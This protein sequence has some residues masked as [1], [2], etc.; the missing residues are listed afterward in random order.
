MALEADLTAEGKCELL[1]IARESVAAAISGKHYTATTSICDLLNQKAGAFV[2]LH[3]KGELRGCIGYIEARLPVYETVAEVAAKAAMSDPRF[4]SVTK[5]E[6]DDIEFEI[7]VLSPLKK[8]SDIQE[9]IVGKHGIMMEH[10]YYRGLLLPQVAVENG[11]D[12]NEFL[13]YTC[14]KAGMDG[15]CYKEAGTDIYI[16]TADVFSE[17]ECGLI[18]ESDIDKKDY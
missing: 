1:R 6:L 4:A 13:R 11:W 7:S 17:R 9:I 15:D 18:Q 2:T 12:K 14:M 5:S 16:F 10:G 3:E 8:I